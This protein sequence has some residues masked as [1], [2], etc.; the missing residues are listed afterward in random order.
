[1][2][3]LYCRLD[4]ICFQ[5]FKN[6]FGTNGV[7][8]SRWGLGVRTP[9]GSADGGD[10]VPLAYEDAFDLKVTNSSFFFQRDIFDHTLHWLLGHRCCTLEIEKPYTTEI[11]FPF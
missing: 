5:Y 3:T 1:M 10:V 4:C 11:N 7:G 9:F 2:K 8:G 6:A